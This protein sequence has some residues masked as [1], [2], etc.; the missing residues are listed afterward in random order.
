MSELLAVINTFPGYVLLGLVAFGD[1]LIGVGFFVF[2]EA[3][4][5]AAGAAW[6]ATGQPWPILL[7]LTCAWAGDLASYAIGRR[8]GARFSLPYLKRLS[9]RRL[10]RRARNALQ[11]RGALFVILSRVLGPTAW[12]TPFLAGSMQMKPLTF[13]SAAAVGVL[14]GAGQFIVL[15][16]I[17]LQGLT[18]LLPFLA[19][20]I[21]SIALGFV[22][23][24]CGLIIWRFSRASNVV[25]TLKIAAMTVVMF[26]GSN[27]AYFFVLNTH[28][29]AALPA[30]MVHSMCDIN[31]RSLLVHPG[32]T[33]LHLPQPVNVILIS[34]GS[35][36]D[37]MTDLNW[38]Q[39]LT[40]SQDRISLAD[41]VHQLA[42]ETPP[43]SELFLSG[44]PADSAFQ[45]A[46][47]LKTREHIRWWEVG[48][49]VSFGAISRDD[50][51]AIKYYR[52]LPVLL[53]DIDPMV[54]KSRD[55]LASQLA[56]NKQFEVAGYANLGNRV[57]EGEYA[58]FETDGR[59][60]IIAERGALTGAE[61][62]CLPFASMAAVESQFT[63][64]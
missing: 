20:H 54:D 32:D 49:Q 27:L 55:L 23:F 38:H 34:N 57:Y 18:F 6:A 7:V 50:E 13:A 31:D 41:F 29:P 9:R 4:F 43:I 44:K 14:I 22:V 24:G 11:K 26:L 16:A 36:A 37:L 51:I 1:T 62:D 48:P 39:N 63:N 60:L 19:D 61:L 64:L 46:G 45:M 35:G 3:A 58:D 12:I 52:H 25:R 30:P 2:G 42:N 8:Y 10:W 47:T 53:H 59:V 33:K 5:L 28:S 17:G 15:G 40:Y 21:W 56:E